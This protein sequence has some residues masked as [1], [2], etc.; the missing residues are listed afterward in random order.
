VAV[1]GSG[2][3]AYSVDG[4][5]WAA[6]TNTTFYSNEYITGIAY[7]GAPGSEKFVAVGNYGKAAYSNN[8]EDN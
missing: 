1:G 4:E 5:T 7:G 2:R 3:A 6:V 8:V